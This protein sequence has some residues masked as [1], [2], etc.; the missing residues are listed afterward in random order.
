MSQGIVSE[1]TEAIS[2]LTCEETAAVEEGKLFVVC[3]EPVWTS[4][5]KGAYCA[6]CTQISRARAYSQQQRDYIA[7]QLD[8]DAQFQGISG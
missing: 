7:R 2:S 4:T 5:F 3:E 6:Y 8:R 1:L